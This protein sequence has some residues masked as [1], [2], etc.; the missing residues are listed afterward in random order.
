MWQHTSY[1]HVTKRLGLLHVAACA[2][3]WSRQSLFRY[4]RTMRTTQ[5]QLTL[6]QISGLNGV[7][8]ATS[9]ESAGSADNTR[10]RNRKFEVSQLKETSGKNLTAFCFFA[11]FLLTGKDLKLKHHSLHVHPSGLTTCI[12]TPHTHTHTHTRKSVRTVWVPQPALGDAT[13][14]LS[15]RPPASNRN[16]LTEQR[17][18][19]KGGGDSLLPRT[20]HRMNQLIL[21][22]PLYT[23]IPS[24]DPTTFMWELIFCLFCCAQTPENASPKPLPLSPPTPYQHQPGLCRHMEQAKSFSLHENN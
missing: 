24:L 5:E 13:S 4:M 20:W 12:H 3:T 18:P 15:S 7:H 8:N 21:Y 10:K 11:F 23:P 6:T 22:S 16:W 9:S 19:W 1:S 14:T 17:W 2:A